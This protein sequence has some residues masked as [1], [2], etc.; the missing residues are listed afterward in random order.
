MPNAP[1]G[2]KP[3]FSTRAGRLVPHSIGRAGQ[4]ITQLEASED[5]LQNAWRVQGRNAHFMTNCHKSTTPWDTR[6]S[7][8][9]DLDQAQALLVRSINS[10]HTPHDRLHPE[11]LSSWIQTR[12]YL[13]TIQIRQGLHEP[14]LLHDVDDAI[15]RLLQHSEYHTVGAPEP[16]SVP[17]AEGSNARIQ[18]RIRRG[19]TDARGRHCLATGSTVGRPRCMLHFGLVGCT[20]SATWSQAR[21]PG[22]EATATDLDSARQHW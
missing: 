8:G 20:H 2:W 14:Q 12:L 22:T 19:F 18:F 15:A 16:R 13:A 11:A 5:D 17:L 7:Y 10:E 9:G 1:I 21:S 3:G 4:A 6:T